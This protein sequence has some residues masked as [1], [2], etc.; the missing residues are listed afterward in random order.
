MRKEEDE[1][2]MITLPEEGKWRTWSIV[3]EI[4]K[5]YDELWKL[6]EDA[7]LSCKDDTIAIDVLSAIDEAMAKYRLEE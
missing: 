7:S 1:M 5:F 4:E 6:H 3:Q 2:K